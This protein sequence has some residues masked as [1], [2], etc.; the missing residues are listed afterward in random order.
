[1]I[2]AIAKNEFLQSF[3][4]LRLAIALLICCTLMPL[5]VFTMLLDYDRRCENFVLNR[6]NEFP[7]DDAFVVPVSE[8]SS[9]TNDFPYPETGK[10]KQPSKLSVFVTGTDD[11]LGGTFVIDSRWLDI[12]LGKRQERNAMASLFGSFDLLLVTKL[13]VGLLAVILGS[14]SM[15]SEREA[16]T[17]ALILSNQASRSQLV[18]GK[19]IGGVSIVLVAYVAGLLLCLLLLVAWPNWSFTAADF[20][21][22]MLMFACFTLYVVFSFLLGVVISSLCRTTGT[23]ST[24]SVGLWLLIIVLSPMLLLY[25]AGI[26]HDVPTSELLRYE[27]LEAARTLLDQVK[28]HFVGPRGYDLYFG[29]PNYRGNA[30]G[31]IDYKIVEAIG[32]IE[33]KH[34]EQERKQ[35]HLANRLQMLTPSGALTNIAGDLAGTSAGSYLLYRWGALRLR[36]ELYDRQYPTIDQLTAI[37]QGQLD[38][39]LFVWDQDPTPDYLKSLNLETKTKTWLECPLFH[40]SSRP[41]PM[42]QDLDDFD[43][44]VEYEKYFDQASIK[45][46]LSLSDCA[47][48]L[49]ATFLC[50]GL[51]FCFMTKYDVRAV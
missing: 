11:A 22:T 9:L 32:A 17:L 12:Q 45:S 14:N 18:I 6:S 15:V 37:S 28:G 35:I 5:S 3:Q 29:L 42:A 7:R 21:A 26:I 41:S 50:F 23:A 36:N 40:R 24:A 27:K 19:C 34:L 1:M 38:P 20:S 8:H 30:G 49:F 48:L 4:S 16:G 31:R 47:S 10:I 46:T 33:Q 2:L 13:A 25:C 39:N 44:V 51:A 43:F